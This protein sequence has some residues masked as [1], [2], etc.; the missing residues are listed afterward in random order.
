MI[1]LLAICGA[2]ICT[3]TETWQRAIPTRMFGARA[4]PAFGHTVYNNEEMVWYYEGI[5]AQQN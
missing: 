1:V 4:N 5:V 3:T 2:N